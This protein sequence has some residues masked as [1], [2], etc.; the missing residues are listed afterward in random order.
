[1]NDEAVVAKG[2]SEIAVATPLPVGCWHL[3]VVAG[4]HPTG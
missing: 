3:R 2:G 1:M 4:N